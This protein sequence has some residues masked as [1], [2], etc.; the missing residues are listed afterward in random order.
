M[1]EPR[2]DGSDARGAFNDAFPVRLP[3]VGVAS[4]AEASMF[5]DSVTDGSRSAGE[6][7]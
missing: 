3:D 4:V 7:R 6:N 2:E 1:A 5:P